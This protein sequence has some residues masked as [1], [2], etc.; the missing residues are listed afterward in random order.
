MIKFSLT[1]LV[2][3]VSVAVLRAN[4]STIPDTTS[5]P[6]GITEK[7]GQFIPDSLWFVTENGDSVNLKSLI[8]KPTVLAFVYFDCPG[9]CSPLL[10]GVSK[11]VSR[12]DMEIGKE[13]QI[14][15]ISI[16]SMDTPA[17]AKQKKHNFAEKV[18]KP[19]IAD[20]WHF[21]TGRNSEIQKITHAAGFGFRRQ[22][23]DFVHSAAIIVVS[24]HAKITRYL[25]GTYFLP[26]DLKMAVVE[27]EG[28][29]TGPTIN[30]V[31]QFCFNYDPSGR[32]Y[33][34]DITRI[35]GTVII[36]LVSLMFV[37]LIFKP[38]KTKP[39]ENKEKL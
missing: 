12:S 15:T 25:F 36:S 2:F 3:L 1:A 38:K 18:N 11:V 26:F 28:E 13:Y 29:Q 23:K 17:K 33:V 32:K 27:A 34:L 39:E 7:T 9:I 24:P 19:G 8:D 21:L 20:G 22:G 14:I 37:I 6:I 30:K 35:T 4:E 31:L 10:D 16:D 5:L